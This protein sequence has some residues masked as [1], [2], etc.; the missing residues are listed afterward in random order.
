VTGKRFHVLKPA[1]E[2]G[3]IVRFLRVVFAGVVGA[4]D[5]KTGGALTPSFV[6]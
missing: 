2:H 1:S 3:L 6:P 5:E 4:S